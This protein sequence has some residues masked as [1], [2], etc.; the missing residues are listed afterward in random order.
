MSKKIGFKE[1]KR[2]AIEA[3][4]DKTY[5]IEARREIKTKNLLYSN[6][7]S[8]EEII[9]VI[10]RCRGQDHEMGPH[11]MVKTVDVHILRKDGW[12]IKF[13]SSIPK[14]FLSAFTG[15]TP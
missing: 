15:S 9:D 5:D 6:A 8:E 2:R 10:S 11:D 3:L 7:V 1:A 4:R 13:Y 12:Y 14:P